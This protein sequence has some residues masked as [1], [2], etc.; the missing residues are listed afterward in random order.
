MYSSTIPILNRDLFHCLLACLLACLIDSMFS[1]LYKT[2]SSSSST[3]ELDSP[4]P[5]AAAAADESHAENQPIR[6]SFSHPLYVA[7]SLFSSS[8]LSLSR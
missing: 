5:Y 7:I 3:E 4:P 2:K 1:K 8:S 6:H